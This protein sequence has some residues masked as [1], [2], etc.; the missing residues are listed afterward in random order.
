MN[1]FLPVVMIC[2]RDSNIPFKLQRLPYI[3]W[4]DRWSW[5]SYGYNWIYVSNCH[6]SHICHI[7]LNIPFELQHLPYIFSKLPNDWEWWIVKSNSS[8]LW[9]CN[10]S[11]YYNNVSL[12]Q[13]Y[14]EALQTAATVS[15]L[16]L[17]D[18]LMEYQIE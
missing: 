18:G 12:Y 15:K 1:I 7:N 17:R 11:L 13:F 10:L 16:C 5:Q 9:F 4:N 6:N 14:D 8:L 2:H 3:F